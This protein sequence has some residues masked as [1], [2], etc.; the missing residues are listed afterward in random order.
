MTNPST[1]DLE[2]ESTT[3]HLLYDARTGAIAHVHRI[4]NHRGATPVSD[5]EAG[6]RA[7]EMAGRLGH[8]PEKLRVLRAE[9]F[10]RSKPQR[11]D[12][13]TRELV[14]IKSVAPK[15]FSKKSGLARKQKP[16]A[17]G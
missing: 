4:V 13:R 3:V 11:V 7:L 12:P 10:D 17:R 6:K 1:G 14:T 5:K 16:K 9:G 2:V 15:R 8:Q